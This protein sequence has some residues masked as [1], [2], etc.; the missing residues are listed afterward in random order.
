MEIKERIVT[1]PNMRRIV[2]TTNPS[3]TNDN[4]VAEVTVTEEGTVSQPGTPITAAILSNMV[5]S[6]TAQTIG[7]VKTFNSAPVQSIGEDFA[8][9][10]GIAVASRTRLRRN[11]SST[12][13]VTVDLPN[14]SG[15]LAR[16]GTIRQVNG[17]G[18]ETSNS[19]ATTTFKQSVTLADGEVITGVSGGG[20]H[21]GSNPAFTPFFDHYTVDGASGTV[22]VTLTFGRK[23]TTTSKSNQ[24]YYWCIT[25]L[26][27]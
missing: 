14:T 11:N 5:D 27:Q 13:A 4:F 20:G 19:T 9:N 8:H 12:T 6:S 23:S 22:T 26:Q 21:D 18:T 25:V 17:S 1:N 10:T 7:G 24:S 3:N 16:R 2:K 15:I